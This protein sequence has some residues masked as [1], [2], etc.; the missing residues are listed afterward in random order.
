MPIYRC[1]I[2]K[3][4]TDKCS[5]HK[6]HLNSTKHLTNIQEHETTIINSFN[7]INNTN[8]ITNNTTNNITNNNVILCGFRH[9]DLSQITKE[10]ILKCF[11]VENRDDCVNAFIKTTNCNPRFPQNM[12][13][14][15]KNVDRKY[16]KIYDGNDWKTVHKNDQIDTFYQEKDMVLEEFISKHKDPYMEKHYKIHE[17]RCKEDKNFYEECKE[18]TVY[19]FHDACDMISKNMKNINKDNAIIL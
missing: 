1:E 14:I 2:C 13:V 11:S 15:V 3:Y 16:M 19:M 9:E 7:T 5:N 18:R 4:V 12:N 8:N 10:D 6:K 17:K